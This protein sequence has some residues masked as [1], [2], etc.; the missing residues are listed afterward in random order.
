V[1]EVYREKPRVP[2]FLSLFWIL[3]VA[4]GLGYA[5][6]IGFQSQDGPSQVYEPGGAVRGPKLI[7][8][9]EPA[10]SANSREA[11]VEGTVRISTVVTSEG[12]PSRCEVL[13][14]L[15]SEEDKTAMEA[16]KQWRFQPGTKDGKPVNVH[17][18]VEV[19]FH[20]M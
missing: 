16:L 12:V 8:Y 18:T 19:V 10:F 13:K 11:Y 20:L 6:G 14:G 17:V 3:S 4:A 1:E 2:V 7:H 9:V 15:N 5:G